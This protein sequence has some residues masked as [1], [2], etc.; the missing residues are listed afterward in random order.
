MTCPLTT[1]LVVE[2]P[3]RAPLLSLGKTTLP[4][5]MCV[6]VGSGLLGLFG[7]SGSENLWLH[8]QFTTSSV[9]Q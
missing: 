8:V 5:R 6:D 1:R 4:L 9:N 2:I 3:P 7:R